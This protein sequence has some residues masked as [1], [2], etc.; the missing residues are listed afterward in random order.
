MPISNFAV[1]SIAVLVLVSILS[2]AVLTP[3]VVQAQQSQSAAPLVAFAALG[4]AAIAICQAESVS[5]LGFSLGGAINC[6]ITNPPGF[7]L[8]SGDGLKQ[9]IIDPAARIIIRSLLQATTQQIVAWIQGD[10]GR[11]VGYVKNLE[12]A[13]RREADIAGGEFLNKITGLNLCGNIG[14]FINISLRTPGFVQRIECSVTDIVRNVNN[15]YRDFSQ[16]GWPAFI[17]ISLEPQNN[18]AGA[19]LIALDAKFEAENRAKER[20]LWGVS[21]EQP[22]LGVNIPVEKD[23][24]VSS[25]VSA[26]T[27]NQPEIEEGEE[28]SQGFQGS[29]TAATEVEQGEGGGQGVQGKKI[30]RTEYETKTPG[31][32]ITASLNKTLGSGIDFAVHAKEF[33][34][35]IA[36]IINALIIKLISVSFAGDDKDSSGE[37]LFDP[38]LSQIS[39]SASENIQASSGKIDESLS[40]ANNASIAVDKELASSYKKLF[41]LQLQNETSASTTAAAEIKTLEDSI[42]KLHEG[43][44]KILLAKADLVNFKGAILEETDSVRVAD[45]LRQMPQVTGT[46]ASAVGEAGV[47][48]GAAPSTGSPKADTLQTIDNTLSSV[49][50]TL[51]L[52]DVVSAEAG[53]IASTTSSASQKSIAETQRAILVAEAQSLSI[54]KTSLQLKAGELR[55]A[56]D[57]RGID[58]VLRGSSDILIGADLRIRHASEVIK[59]AAEAIKRP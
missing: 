34:E 35:A 23:C 41:A 40:L 38:G 31:E 18:P 16:G 33:D 15:F 57:P 19:Y 42:A 5:I 44:A 48:A 6:S 10:S 32:V 51:S 49:S 9:W 8:L 54:S 27:G 11:N 55:R 17:R 26:A 37:G 39:L 21:P 52:L 3:A 20:I 47:S 22:F 59:V 58:S 12:Q 30:C 25:G 56:E 2:W 53:K 1:K 13:V 14:A 36:T 43:K 50:S 46:V 28:G 29:V 4:A 7:D 24:I 45:L